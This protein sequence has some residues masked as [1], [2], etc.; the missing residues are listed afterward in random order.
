MMLK[1]ENSGGYPVEDDAKELEQ[2]TGFTSPEASLS[3]RL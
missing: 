2:K 3:A 1:M